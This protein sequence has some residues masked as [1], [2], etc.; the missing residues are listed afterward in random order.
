VTVYAKHFGRITGTPEV[1]LS[2]ACKV[3]FSVNSPV[4]VAGGCKLPGIPFSGIGAKF[5]AATSNS[6]QRVFGRWHS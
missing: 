1:I 3:S 2:S 4:G 6:P 5:G